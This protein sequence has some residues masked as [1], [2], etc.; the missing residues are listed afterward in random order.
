LAL[1]AVRRAGAASLGDA[2]VAEGM[3]A[4]E[5]RAVIY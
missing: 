3:D 1:A 2:A 5:A 4:S